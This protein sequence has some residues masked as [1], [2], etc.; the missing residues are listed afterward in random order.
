MVRIS[1]RGRSAAEVRR[2]Q[3]HLECLEPRLT[4]SVF[5]PTVSGLDAVDLLTT[6]VGSSPG[7]MVELGAVVAGADVQQMPSVAI[8]PHA[9]DHLVIAYMDRGLTTSGYAGLGASVSF[10]AGLTW[11]S[12]TLP[13][14]AGFDEGASN[15]ITRF[16]DDGRVFVSFMA[17]T[18]LGPKP[19]LTN[20]HLSRPD[21]GGLSERALGFKANNGVFVVRS[22]DGGLSWDSPATVAAQTYGG[23]T[24]VPFDI[25]PD[26]WPSTPTRR[27]PM[28]TRTRTMAI[29][30]SS[31]ADTSR[32][33][34]SPASR[35]A[36]AG[37][38]FC[39]PC[40]PTVVR[41]GTSGG[42]RPINWGC[43]PSLCPKRSAW[44]R[45]RRD[46]ARSTGR[47]SAWDPKATCT[48][49]CLIST[50]SKC[51]I[52]WT[53]A[54]ASRH[55]IRQR[56]KGCPSAM[57]RTSRRP[58]PAA[59]RPTASALKSCARSSPIRRGPDMCTRPRRSR[60]WT[61][62]A[63]SSIRPTSGSRG[64]PTTAAPGRPRR[65]WAR[66]RPAS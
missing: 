59:C 4:M 47:T 24:E 40:Q 22:D 30:M 53:A 63:A 28:A 66:E 12:S 7:N 65:S 38:G 27:C 45:H 20:P 36:M 61:P 57:R 42:T 54:G 9:P 52:R 25:M 10:D 35:T 41:R 49:R 37:P 19:S 1:R 64:P 33:N 15:P 14:P 55:R 50:P 32:R 8:D 17:A 31:G 60:R 29:C 62:W 18:F 2:R 16:D 21:L 13:L 23:R 5:G 26:S 44:A 3:P 43:P 56:A 48:C 34:N 11:H 39:W 51:F 6:S 46:W 58:R